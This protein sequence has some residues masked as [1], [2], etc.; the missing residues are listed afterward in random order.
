MDTPLTKTQLKNHQSVIYVAYFILFLDILLFLAWF[1]AA[2]FISIK[3]PD[4]LEEHVLILL[5]FAQTIV[6]FT[7]IDSWNSSKTKQEIIRNYSPLFWIAL[8]LGLVSLSGDLFLLTRQFVGEHPCHDVN[9]S[10]IVIDSSGVVI[11]LLSI[12]WFIVITIRR[13]KYLNK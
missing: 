6:I 12:I 4:S 2:I 5:H 7:V 9:I 3:C 13:R 11:C 1:A 10:H 8:G